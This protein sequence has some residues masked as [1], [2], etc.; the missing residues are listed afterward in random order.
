MPRPRLAAADAENVGGNFEP[1]LL[2]VLRRV[3]AEEPLLGLKEYTDRVREEYTD[4]VLRP[5]PG[6]EQVR[7]RALSRA[8]ETLRTYAAQETG[9]LWVLIQSEGASEQLTQEGPLPPSPPLPPRTPP[10]PPGGCSSL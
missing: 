10:P 8:K 1:E 5:L 6:V 2:K 9:G 3:R 7:A 4:R